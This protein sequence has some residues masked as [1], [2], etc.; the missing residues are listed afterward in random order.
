MKA[1][2]KN[3]SH[4][5]ILAILILVALVYR[6]SFT[7]RFFQDDKL[8]LELAASQNFL[9]VIPG[10]NHFRP[11]SV[12]GFYLLGE[13]LFGYDPL[14]YHLLGFAVFAVTLFLIFQTAKLITGN[15]KQSLI[16]TFLYGL[17]ISLFANFFWV[18][19]SQ[20]VL[21]GLFFF[22]SLLLFY[23]KK[24]VWLAVP[25]FLLGLLSNEQILSLIFV[26]PVIS[27]LWKKPFSRYIFCAIA[28]LGVI[29][30]GAKIFILGMPTTA[31]YMVNLNP[32][33]AMATL[34]WYV[35]RAL[36][37]PEGVKLTADWLFTG[38]FAMFLLA[39]FKIKLNWQRIFFGIFWFIT[40][41]GIFIFLPNHMS[42]HYLTVAL[43]GSSL[44]ISELLPKKNIF[45]A[46]ALALYLFL[47]V[48]GLDFLAKTHWIILKNTGPIG[49][50]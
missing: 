23:S 22:G 11:V 16:V 42:A 48:R 28:I 10:A 1:W 13:T 37:L 44:I 41:L 3:K 25:V 18:A 49:Q 36:N 2:F 24:L 7:S 19:N 35:L 26:L 34:R 29:W 12:Q 40:T 30:V 39:L 21:G 47:T 20:F 9:A 38:A 31:D 50:F 8:N 15:Q 32:L 45:L 17:N 5:I 33:T 4:L 27:F 46:V 43:F 14:G 6:N